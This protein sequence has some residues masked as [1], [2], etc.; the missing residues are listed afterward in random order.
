MTERQGQPQPASWGVQT[1]YV[2]A[3]GARRRISREAV[4]RALASM[5]ARSPRPAAGG[6][7]FARP[8]ERLPAGVAG[9]VAEDGSEERLTARARGLVRMPPMS[10]GYH[11]LRMRD[12]SER[13]LV[14]APR[15]CFLPAMR[16]WGWA[17]QVYAMHSQQSWGMGELAD[18]RMLREWSHGHGAAA[19]LINPLHAPRPTVPQE[20]SPYFPSSRRYRNPL[21]LTVEE[22]PGAAERPEIRL[23]AA[24]ARALSA[25]PV[26]DRDRIHALKMRALALL[27]ERFSA[28]DKFDQYCREGG[29]EL[30]RYASFC[31]LCERYPGPWQRWPE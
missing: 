26:I 7:V 10:A 17:A 30:L 20:P 16:G 1:A 11:T 9:I 29:D 31:V 27:W 23:I 25:A 8:G 2:D 22:V 5:G 21:Y 12:G 13:L 14:T 3:T 18:L 15:R 19:L 6:P 4:Q 24:E 28:D